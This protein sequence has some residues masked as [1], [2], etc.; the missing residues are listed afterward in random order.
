MTNAQR[1]IKY[2]AICL[3]VLL[4]ISIVCGIIGAVSFLKVFFSGDQVS[5]TT[6]RYEITENIDSL[7]I[8]VSAAE[9]TIKEGEIFAVESNLKNLTVKESGGTLTVK[10]AKSL[11]GIYKGAVLTVYV[12]AGTVFRNVDI[13]TGAGK[14]TVDALSSTDLTLELGAGAVDIGTLA[15][16]AS[17]EIEGGAGKLTVGGGLLK[18][19]DLSMGVGQLNLTSSFSGE[20]EL[21]LGV[22]QSNIT[23]IGNKADYSLDIDKGVGDVT[24][25]GEKFSDRGS[26]GNGKN[27]I[28][29]DGGVGDINVTFIEGAV[30]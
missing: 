11:A 10:E 21:E 16:T 12:P 15:A 27:S 1:I 3:A 17:A 19:L 4:I 14:L 6:R 20:C 18:N 25:D 30:K 28:E 24:V 13:K 26:S 5:D 22:G 2:I 8:I 9:L 7:K 23:V 29:I